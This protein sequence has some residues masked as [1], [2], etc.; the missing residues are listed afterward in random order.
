MSEDDLS[1]SER[2]NLASSVFSDFRQQAGS[3]DPPA[4][5]YLSDQDLM[6]ALLEDMRHYADWRGID[7]PRALENSES[8][9]RRRRN[10]EEH[11]YA[12]GQEVDFQYRDEDGYAPVASRG[13]VTSIFPQE[14]GGVTYYARFL[15]EADARPFQREDLVPAR[16]FPAFTTHQ[17]PVTGLAQAERLLVET[18]ARIRSCLIRNAP[19]PDNDISD[20]DA[21]SAVLDRICSLDARDILG[22]L[23]PHVAAWTTEITRPWQPAPAGQPPQL[24]AL[25]FPQPVPPVTGPPDQAPD[26]G[27]RTTPVHRA[28]SPKQG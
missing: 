27:S 17:G 11:P 22:L 4:Y 14:H 12:L 10:G 5:E 23:E 24:S 26:L 16:P 18:S 25:D 21:I 28:H 1:R 20:R 6:T 2:L 3:M 15:G 9:Y 13:I 7:F 19:T 8:A